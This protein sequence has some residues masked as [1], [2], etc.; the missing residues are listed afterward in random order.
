[1]LKLFLSLAF[2]F[3]FLFPC[4][5]TTKH[6]EH[7][8]KH[9]THWQIE[10]NSTWYPLYIAL[11]KDGFSQKELQPFFIALENNF[12]Q[13]PMGNKVKELYQA[14]FAP[15]KPKTKKDIQKQKKENKLGIPYPWFPGYVTTENAKK[16]KIFIKENKEFFNKAEKQYK[17]PQEVLSA[18]IYVETW[19][20]KFLGKF[21]P[22]IMLSSMAIS[23]DLAMLPDYTKQIK[24]T[25]SQTIWMQNAIQK[26]ADWAYKELKALLIYS[27]KNNIDITKTPSSIYGAVGY[28]QFMPSN[29]SRFAIDGNDDKIIDLFHAPDAIL[30]VA[31][32][33]HK[34]GWTTL[35]PTFKNQVKVL[36]RYNYSTAYAHTILALAKLTTQT[37]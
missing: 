32:F 5:A 15:K 31:N 4:Y 34:Q 21:N 30:S 22:L 35:K 7:N 14:K 13:K 10:K 24:L 16:C 18:L 19:H 9:I 36:K 29:I 8:E 6:I 33:L 20:G 27:I 23:K 26:K 1:M 25:D 28:G 11:K 12:S 17:I 37:K 3:S 2:C